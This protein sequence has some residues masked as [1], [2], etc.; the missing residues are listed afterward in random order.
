MDMN[1]FQYKFLIWI[2]FATSQIYI[3]FALLLT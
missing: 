1:K 3:K 2:L